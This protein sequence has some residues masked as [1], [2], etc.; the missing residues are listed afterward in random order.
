MHIL[1][2][3]V[4]LF[5]VYPFAHS[6]PQK[7][8]PKYEFQITS[9]SGRFPVKGPYGTGPMKS[10]LSLTISYPDFSTSSAAHTTTCDHSWPAGTHAGPT[11]WIVCQDPSVQWRLPAGGWKSFSKF[12]LEFWVSTSDG[13]GF[14]APQ[15]LTQ[16]PGN[17][18]DPNAYL[19][20]LQMG[21][22]SP[23]MCQ[24]NGPLSA[25]PGPVVMVGHKATARPN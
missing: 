7:H 12:R 16:N 1:R 24:L 15:D 8:Q 23:E 20:C 14:H 11:D 5:L 17:P 10:S 25:H 9:L 3:I 19:S 4:S 6:F 18:S 21:K 13:A 2:S 22:M